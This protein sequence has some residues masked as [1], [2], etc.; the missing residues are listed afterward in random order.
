M[1]LENSNTVSNL[2]SIISNS[3]KVSNKILDMNIN[4]ITINS[5]IVKENTENFETR[6][7]NLENATWKLEIPKINLIAQIA[8]G[9][10]EEVLNKYIGHFVETQKENGNIGLA[11]HNR[12]YNVNYFSRIKELEIDDEIIYTYNNISKKYKVINKSIIKDTD[13]NL[14]ENTNDNR[15]TL[16]TCVEDQPEYRRCVQGIEVIE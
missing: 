9:T 2:S 16:I 7:E 14:L 15:I 1:K 8:E 12:G 11:A 4:N 3:N 10:E 13:W 5:N 6:K